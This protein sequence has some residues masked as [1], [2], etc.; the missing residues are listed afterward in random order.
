MLLRVHLTDAGDCEFFSS[1]L[2]LLLDP[3]IVLLAQLGETF[4]SINTALVLI[5]VVIKLQTVCPACLVQVKQ[6]F[7][8]TFVLAIVDRNRVVMLVQATVLGEQAHWA[9]VADV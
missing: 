1:L 7:L 9:H 3:L 8:L 2:G 5:C 4:E 6:H